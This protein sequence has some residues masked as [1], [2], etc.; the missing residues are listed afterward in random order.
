MRLPGARL[1][2]D[3][4]RGVRI[5]AA[6]TYAGMSDLLPLEEARAWAQASSDLR[7]TYESLA[8]RPEA[9]VA[10]A[11]FETAERDVSKAVR[12]YEQALRIEPRA[13]TARANLAD[14]LRRLGEEARAEELLREGLVLDEGNA[15]LRHALGLSLVRSSRSEEALDELRCAVELAPENPRFVYVL[16]IALN[17]LGLESDALQVMREAQG[18]FDGDFDIAMVLASM[19]RDSGDTEAALDIAYTLARRHPESQE[20]VALLRSLQ[21]IP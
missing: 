3:A 15:A 21:A 14:T 20:V 4:I 12:L 2:G 13:V 19:L 7:R 8:N 16:G 9:L 11:V 10:L 17:S 5:E 6:S 1:L 18:R